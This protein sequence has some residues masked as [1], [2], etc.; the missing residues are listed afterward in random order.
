M[1]PVSARGPP[2]RTGIT[3]PR[4]PAQV[5]RQHGASVAT[6]SALPITAEG[7]LGRAIALLRRDEVAEVGDR[8]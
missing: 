4:Q 3:P 1:V 5:T 8:V 6:I 2:W 7:Q